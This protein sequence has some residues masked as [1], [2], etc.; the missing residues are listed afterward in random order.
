MAAEDLAAA[1]ESFEN[2]SHDA[3]EYELL[4]RPVNPDR[5]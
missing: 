3:G 4:Y 5:S 2:S 1:F